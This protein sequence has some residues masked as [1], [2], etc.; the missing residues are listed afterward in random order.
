[1][2]VYLLSCCLLVLGPHKPSCV[3][4]VMQSMEMVW[5]LTVPFCIF[6]VELETGKEIAESNGALFF[7]T[8]AKTGENVRKLF[9]GIADRLPD[10]DEGRKNFE[11]SFVL[12]PS[13]PHIAAPNRCPCK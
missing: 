7:E 10:E 5:M 4:S 6:Q 12:N 9:M 8:S 1:M 11:E 13:P 3:A 2:V